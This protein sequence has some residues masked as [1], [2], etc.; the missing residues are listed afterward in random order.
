M[1]PPIGSVLRGQDLDNLLL[2]NISFNK[3]GLIAHL[4][5]FDGHDLFP[6]WLKLIRCIDEFVNLKYALSPNEWDLIKDCS[7]DLLHDKKSFTFLLT[8]IRCK[9]GDAVCERIKT[10]ILMYVGMKMTYQKLGHHGM[11]FNNIA[12]V[13]VFCQ[14]R[15]LYY[16]AYLSLIRIYAKGMEKTCFIDLL[17]HFQYQIDFIMSSITSAL[18]SMIGN[19]CIDGY[20]AIVRDFGIEYSIPYNQLD[21]LFLEPQVMTELDILQFEKT[22][23]EW[24]VST[25]TPRTLYSYA[26]LKYAVS[27]VEKMFEGYGINDSLVLSDAKRMVMD[28]RGRF[29]EDYSIKLS[30]DE[31]ASF[32]STYP[33]LKLSSEATEYFE[34]INER[35][36]FF[37]HEGYYYSTILLMIRYIENAVYGQL[38]KN[39]R[40]RIKAGFVFEKKVKALLEQYGFKSTEIKRIQQQEFDVICMKDGCAYNFQCKNNYLDI[41]LLSLQNIDKVKR[42]N[43]RLVKYYIKALEKEN[44]RTKLVQA[45][46][47]VEH[48]ENYVVARFPIVMNHERFIPFNNLENWL[49][50]QIER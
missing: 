42:Q 8:I 35:P 41:N 44:F 38:R 15:R 30:E 31:F 3:E 47:D 46:F 21:D 23:E 16:V 39:R 17:C 20:E 32:S 12:E 43:N 5:K 40:Y 50:Q 45:H 48:V 49:I 6:K 7:I 37:Q 11:E 2:A 18:H 9:F 13:I 22:K 34:A 25:E 4:S 24:I 33:H 10:I 26:E 28:L 27:Q 29:I 19:G 14:S 36:A 1:I